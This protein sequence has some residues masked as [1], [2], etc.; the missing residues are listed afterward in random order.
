MDFPTQRD[1]SSDAESVSISWRHH[2]IMPLL[3][4]SKRIPKHRPQQQMFAW[5][6][7]GFHYCDVIMGAVASQITSITI[8][9]STV[10]SDADQRKH[11]SSAS[12]AFVR[13]IHRGLVN[14]PHKCPVTR[15]MFP[16]D[17]VIMETEDQFGAT[18]H[19]ERF[20]IFRSNYLSMLHLLTHKPSYIY[21]GSVYWYG[22]TLITVWI[23]NHVPSKMWD[24]I[25]YPFRCNRWSLGM[26]K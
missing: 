20:A 17:D 5:K 21:Q 19:F 4:S 8:V 18:R 2:V 10:Y 22:L 16:F 15:K 3:E 7:T 23:S 1:Q 6:K 11:Q 24:E 26:D 13:G 12:L 25:T 14:S 9:Y